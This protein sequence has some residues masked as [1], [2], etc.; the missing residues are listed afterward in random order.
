MP[1]G[2]VRITVQA[3]VSLCLFFLLNSISGYLELSFLQNISGIIIIAIFS[4]V[5]VLSLMPDPSDF[6]KNIRIA[7][8]LIVVPLSILPL[9][10]LGLFVGLADFLSY[11]HI[12]LITFLLGILI[13]P[14]SEDNFS[15][16]SLEVREILT[17]LPKPNTIGTKKTSFFG[18]IIF[19]L[20]IISLIQAGKFEPTETSLSILEIESMTF[21]Q[22]EYD[23]GGVE[24]VFSI[25]SNHEVTY[26]LSYLVIHNG[27][28]ILSESIVISSNPS[29][30]VLFEVPTDFSSSG[31]WR[32]EGKI[33]SSDHERE[34]FHNFNIEG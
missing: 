28:L 14:F 29:K 30:T 31:E 15:R 24:L 11:S 19:L 21:P 20:A 34:V 27:D 33:T 17:S 12:P 4:L 32:L 2:D 9:S 6:T 16:Y 23:S 26:D 1:L 3:R 22:N 25:Y 5:S 10:V 13:I 8:V 18:S 7:V